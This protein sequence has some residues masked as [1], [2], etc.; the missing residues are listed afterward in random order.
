MQD[1]WKDVGRYVSSSGMTSFLLFADSF[2][3]KFPVLTDCF[4]GDLLLS[5][6]LAAV[7]ITRYLPR[8]SLHCKI[9][10]AAIFIARIFTLMESL[11]CDIRLRPGKETRDTFQDCTPALK[12]MRSPLASSTLLI[13]HSE[14]LDVQDRRTGRLCVLVLSGVFSQTLFHRLSVCESW[15]LVLF[16]IEGSRTTED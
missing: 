13:N 3:G 10:S 9:S 12:A 2:S 6:C 7:F 14:L 1:V 15:V 11:L 16:V 8:W 5:Y 4:A